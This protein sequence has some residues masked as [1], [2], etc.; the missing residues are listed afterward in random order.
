MM[1]HLDQELL[2][3]LRTVVP[4]GRRILMATVHE[5]ALLAGLHPSE[6]FA[7]VPAED[8][9][10][11][12]DPA[13]GSSRIV[14]LAGP[15]AD[16]DPVDHGEL[17]VIVSTGLL[18]EVP[19]VYTALVDLRRRCSPRT[20]VVVTL[21]NR[22]WRPVLGRTRRRPMPD[23]PDYNWLPPDEVVNLLEQ[24]GFEIVSTHS[25]VL[26][27]FSIPVV[28]RFVNRWLAPLPIVRALGA[29][30]LVVARPAPQRST[31]TPSVSVIVAARNEAGNI[32]NLVDRLPRLS[33]DQELIFVEGG[34][35]DETWDEIV[36]HVTPDDIDAPVRVSAYRQEGTGKGDAVRLGF[37]R[38]TGD[39]LVILDADL[40]VPPEE[41][42]R[43]I[44][45]LTS[46][47]CEFANGSRLVYPMEDRAMQ[48]LNIAGNRIFGLV[49]SFLLGQPVRDTLCGSKAM[50]RTDYERLAAQRQFFGDFDPFG[51]FD[52]L[53]GAARMQLRI[54]DI[55]VH[56]KERVY[57]ST[58]I[59][60]FRH[61]MLLIRMTSFAARRLRFV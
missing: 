28:S 42:P 32:A 2:R 37:A 24:S 52:L 1:D 35:T 40:S 43:F 41:L 8:G 22:A 47:S 39:I 14:R 5:P 3:L 58:N 7:V 31:T 55:P 49:F 18:N 23:G 6:G 27:P 59:S 19:D 17:D 11:P 33:S 36:R 46:G 60:R 10:P 21:F 4:D 13:G 45:A 34:S 25:S 38:A 61:G 30:S 16:I 50:W 57:G 44:E 26:L 15:L 12:V 51:D 29:V 54:R 9:N 48:Y 53:F 56:Y 20:R